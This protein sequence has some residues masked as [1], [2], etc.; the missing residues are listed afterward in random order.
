MPIPVPSLDDRKFQ[1][2]VDEAK[3]RIPRY[4]P[5]WT[6]HNVS[7]P[8][9][10]LIEL[11]AWMTEQHIFRLNQVPDKNLLT[12]LN[13]IGMSLEPAKPAKGDV[14]FTLGAAPTPE[15]RVIIPAWTEVAT[16][17]TETREAIAFTTDV[18]VEV[19][20]PTF[21]W[22]LTTADGQD[23]KDQSQA[24]REE[25]AFD[26]WGAPPTSPQCLYL[27]F[28]QDLSAHT[29]VLQFQCD[30]LGIGIDPS[31]PPWLWE[32][33]RGNE[34]KWEQVVI[35]GDTTA[36]LNQNGE[37]RFYLPPQCQPQRLPRYEAA[38]VVRC[39]PID[40]PA[41]GRAPYARSPRVRRVSAYSIGITVPITHALPV[42]PEVLGVSNGQPGQ[43]FRLQHRDTL[44]PE[45]PE[46]VVQVSTT[47]GG[48][49]TWMQVAD[50]GDSTSEDKSTGKKH[51]ILDPLTGEV[52]FGPVIRQR[53][54]TEPQFGAIPL[55][56][57]TIRI[58]RYR[59]GG[60]V[61]GNVAEGRVKVLKTTLPYV[62][63]VV[64]RTPITGG[65]EA[66]SIE[67]AKL[68]GPSR[69]RTRFRAVTAEDFEYLSQE[70]EGVGRVRCLQPRPDDPAAPP[71]GTVTLLVIP[72]LPPL[73]D[74]ELDRYIDLHESLSKQDLRLAV[75]A[76]LQS[77]LRLPEGTR[78]RLGEFLDDRR[79]LTARVEI[80][81]PQ[82]VWVTVQTRIRAQPKAEPERV[83]RDVKIALYQFL[84]PLFGGAD[85][86]GWTFGQPLT[87][88][89]VYAL[90]HNIPGVD[91]ATELNLY[92]IDITNPK[93][94]RVGQSAQVIQVPPNA[95]IVSYY[96][97]VYLPQ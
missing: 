41:L 21:R 61:G 5:S 75:E 42:G 56:G 30:K 47:D 69:L 88:D 27:G 79:L 68:R 24:L 4:S 33:W 57:S 62:A 26:I 20:P 64:N 89:K 12:F 3:R 53:D 36:G 29:L 54:G 90:I 40:K 77:E 78:L 25:A 18:E 72:N 80:R 15:R 83:R 19:L 84:H 11:F 48:W 16:E 94:Q 17:R 91:Y 92:P 85:R 23:Y 32:V 46:E 87:I 35:A 14:T 59:I 9:I 39:T 2:L 81:E 76:Q 67:D 1:Q 60:G 71:A 70:V 74:L 45:G 55:L 49:E 97:N 63:S 7:D 66:Q 86:K 31:D 82:Y 22:V 34:R 73:K 93:G 95:V 65:E 43:K 8:G 51:Y 96:H 58:L 50:F 44:R 28:E 52:E 37:L 38:T 13:L 6:D 10:T